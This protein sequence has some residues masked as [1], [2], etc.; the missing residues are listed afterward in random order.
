[1]LQH[2]LNPGV[3]INFSDM[4]MARETRIVGLGSQQKLR[5]SKYGSQQ[6]SSVRDRESDSFSNVS[7]V[8]SVDILG[9]FKAVSEMVQQGTLPQTEVAKKLPTARLDFQTNH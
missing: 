7:N 9:Q 3:R 1:M 2:D 5:E 4:N 6:T 8:S